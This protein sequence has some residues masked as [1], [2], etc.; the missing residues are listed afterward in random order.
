MDVQE[1]GLGTWNGLISLRIGKSGGEFLIIWETITFLTRALLHKIFIKNG[2]YMCNI[3]IYF[4]DL[5]LCKY[6]QV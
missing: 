1:I 2:K 6:S 4:L 5:L 3:T